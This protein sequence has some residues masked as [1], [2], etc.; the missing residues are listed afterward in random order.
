MAHDHSHGASVPENKLWIALALTGSFMLVEAVAGF[1]SGSLALLSDAAHMLTDVAA[2]GISLAAVRFARRA[3]DAK[4]SFGY[5]R[6]EILAAAFNAVVLFLVAFYILFEAVQRF[7]NPEAVGSG[8]M[9]VVATLGL[10][11]NLIAMRLLKASSTESLNVKSAYLEVWADMIGSI[12]VIAGAIVIRLTAWQWV[13]SA[14]AVGIG[15]WV[16]P[17]T[18]KLLSESLHILLQGVPY[19]FDLAKIE[20][21]MRAVPGVAEIHD[22]HLWALTSGRNVLTAHLV[23]AAEVSDEQTVLQATSELLHERYKITG[24]TLQIEPKG[25][26]AEAAHD[27]DDH[28][29]HRE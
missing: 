8:T 10:I 2:L 17:R 22:L 23:L 6:F 15:F 11:I 24:T 1:L 21:D 25:F 27:G 13:D 20:A 14:V 12:G 28:A 9:L 18:W 16:I 7:R 4:R 26:H 29:E 19:G 5:Y 3:P